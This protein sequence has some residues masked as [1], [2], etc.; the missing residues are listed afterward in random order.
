MLT[1]EQQLMVLKD[2][3][4]LLSQP[5]RWTRTVLARDEDSLPVFPRSPGAC[6]FCA[7]GALRR[8][9]PEEYRSQA[10]SVRLRSPSAVTARPESRLTKAAM[11][12]TKNKYAGIASFNDD[13]VTVFQVLEVYDSAIETL[14]KEI[15]RA[16]T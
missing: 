10:G 4:K 15:A 7:I 3:R 2:A 12:T 16:A 5:G 6:S 11:K 14:K 1:L 13:A 8:V 9:F